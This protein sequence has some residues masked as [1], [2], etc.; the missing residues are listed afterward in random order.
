MI[1]L[2]VWSGGYEAPS[3]Q[4]FFS[5]EAAFEKAEEWEEGMADGDWID[6]LE[7]NPDTKIVKRLERELMTPE[8]KVTA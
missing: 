6:V 3:Y 7:L 1:Y 2:T 5:A 8:G 4:M